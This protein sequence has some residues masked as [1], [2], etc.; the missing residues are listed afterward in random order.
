MNT[1]CYASKPFLQYCL[2]LPF[3]KCHFDFLHILKLLITILLFINLYVFCV[4]QLCEHKFKKISNL[5]YR[6]I[7]SQWLIR[8]PTN[9][10]VLTTTLT[11]WHTNNDTYY[12]NTKTTFERTQNGEH[13][14][15]TNNNSLQNK[16]LQL[17]RAVTSWTYLKT[18][19]SNS[20]RVPQQLTIVKKSSTLTM[21]NRVPQQQ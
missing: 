12:Q 14:E 5:L 3:D 6:Q 20:D 10:N 7:A 8:R 16:W 19:T 13:V 17:N 18:N 4:C 2:I 11:R 21:T 9:N 1:L 15:D